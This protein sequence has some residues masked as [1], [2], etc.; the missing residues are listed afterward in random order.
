MRI[1]DQVISTGRALEILQWYSGHFPDTVRYF[2]GVVACGRQP[3][4]APHHVTMAD[5]GRL[6]L[7]N[8][9]LSATDVP[10]LL[11]VDARTEFS[12]VPVDARLEDAAPG[13]PLL[14]AA[15]RLYDRF[16]I[17]AGIGPA[18]RSKL[19]HLK[20]PLLIPIGDRQLSVVYGAAAG[21]LKTFWEA[22][23]QDL[24]AEENLQAF[25][26]L[27]AELRKPLQEPPSRHLLA[28]GRLRWL[29][30]LAWTLGG[31]SQYAA[32]PE[33]TATR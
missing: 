11:A 1:G 9:N 17:G 3:V 28:L 18:K 20:R 31:D 5:M 4:Q 29:D 33:V 7:M 16:R 25:D 23:R 32:Q 10:R 30:I 12:A 13:S 19:L 21:D 22:I 6:V 24:L 2:D 15:E 8:T 26:E 27:E 14:A